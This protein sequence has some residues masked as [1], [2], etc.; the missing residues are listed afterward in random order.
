MFSLS[1]SNDQTRFA[2]FTKYQENNSRKTVSNAPNAPNAPNARKAPKD[3]IFY[4][5]NPAISHAIDAKHYF[6]YSLERK[7]S[8][9][10]VSRTFHTKQTWQ[11]FYDVYKEMKTKNAYEYIRYNLPQK[12]HLDLEHYGEEIFSANTQE[13]PNLLHQLDCKALTSVIH[14]LKLYLT[15]IGYSHLD[16]EDHLLLS[17][18]TFQRRKTSCHIIF[19]S[20]IFPNCAHLNQFV[21]EFTSFLQNLNPPSVHEAELQRFL[22]QNEKCLIDQS[23]YHRDFT[24]TK[25]AQA[26]RMIGSWKFGQDPTTALMIL[27]P[28]TMNK[29]N[30][31]S[32]EE[33]YQSLVQVPFTEEQLEK[34]VYREI[35][36]NYAKMS[37]SQRKKFVTGCS[38]PTTH[39]KLLKNEKETTNSDEKEI[40]AIIRLITP[41]LEKLGIPKTLI[42]AAQSKPDYIY[43]QNDSIKPRKCPLSNG[44][45]H[46][47]NNA[48]VRIQANGDAMYSCF[49]S[50]CRGKYLD[51]GVNV[52][53]PTS[54]MTATQNPEGAPPPPVLSHPLIS[55]MEH[56][57]THTLIDH[58]TVNVNYITDALQSNDPAQCATARLI[59]I[60]SPT[61]TGKTTYAQQM[62]K[63]LLAADPQSVCVALSPRRS[64]T[65]QH[66]KN[67][68]EMG[69]IHYMKDKMLLPT[70]KRIISTLDS[71]FKIDKSI[72]ILYIDEVESLLEH[73][74][75]DTLKERNHVWAKLLEVCSTA[76]KVVVT[77]ADFGDLSTTF[78]T[79]VIEAQNEKTSQ[80]ASPNDEPTKLIYVENL[81]SPESLQISF[82]DTNRQWFRELETC[83]NDPQS[84]IFIGCDSKRDAQNLHQKIIAWLEEETSANRMPSFS[85]ENILLYTSTDGDCATLTDADEAWADAKVIICS[86]TIIYGVDYNNKEHPFTAVMGY[87]T[88]QGFTMGADK[89]RQQLRRARTISKPETQSWHM[90]IHI[91]QNPKDGKL[92][93]FYPTDSNAVRLELEQTC[94]SYAN[95]LSNFPLNITTDIRGNT[96][97]VCDPISRL[98]VEF[99][100]KRNVSKFSLGPVLSQLL[101]FENHHVTKLQWEHLE[102][103]SIWNSERFMPLLHQNEKARFA[104]AFDLLAIEKSQLELKRN[105]GFQKCET[106]AAVELL[107]DFFGIY[108]F[109]DSVIESIKSSPPLMLFLGKKQTFRDAVFKFQR[110]VRKS[111]NHLGDCMYSTDNPCQSPIDITTSEKHLLNVLQEAE[112]IMQWKRFQCLYLSPDHIRALHK[113]PLEIDTNR[114]TLIQNIGKHHFPPNSEVAFKKKGDKITKYHLYQ[115]I[116]KVY[117]YFCFTMSDDSGR[118]KSIISS[119]CIDIINKDNIT[120]SQ[121]KSSVE[122]E[123]YCDCCGLFKNK[124]KYF[125]AEKR[126]CK[127]CLHTASQYY[128]PKK[129]VAQL[130]ELIQIVFFFCHNGHQRGSLEMSFRINE[131]II[132]HHMD[133]SIEPSMKTLLQTDACHNLSDVIRAYGNR[134][135]I[136]QEDE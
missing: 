104:D 72:A 95:I 108:Q 36:D 5:L 51:L 21:D 12:L 45:T 76:K 109:T 52:I 56:F 40:D 75:A 16:V 79:E 19:Q 112:N 136:S 8:K 122:S 73:V 11:T 17:A 67:F 111:S 134:C 96:S 25:T 81:K 115:W 82:T 124:E 103:H 113:E 47:N 93:Q 43:I 58:R 27:D 35:P 32:K 69:F 44:G 20:I 55:K 13:D 128:I 119:R 85:A 131:D 86:P 123:K 28:R 68:R 3:K 89:V 91:F 29:R 39:I 117:A 135:C 116:C 65:A 100:R 14:Y 1:K 31:F 9:N 99:L 92:K 94:T 46:I 62:F 30:H 105:G 88:Q 121:M 83:L 132:C 60:K 24:N 106:T 64:V 118:K 133:Q 130:T 38:K 125:R 101:S 42:K 53:L 129:H 77:D 90:C 48:S 6:V 33:F 2:N 70:C 50:E 26:F 57:R 4:R 126:F 15:N 98:Y 23:I 63:E 71:L 59:C 74:F 114:L 80:G 127:E 34:A 87:Y 78:F 97:I 54:T 107:R 61:G 10:N 102:A 7:D 49:G 66:E 41:S 37:S 110:L 18:S 22:F 120:N 84:K